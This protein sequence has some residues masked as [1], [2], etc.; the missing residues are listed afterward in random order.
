MRE[1]VLAVIN[2]AGKP[3]TAVRPSSELVVHILIIRSGPTSKLL[4]TL[5]APH[6]TSFCCAGFGKR[7]ANTFGSNSD[8]RVC[9][10]GE[11]WYSVLEN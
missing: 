11:L 5:T 4:V 10:T 6:G 8:A 3:F 9:A 1:D 2:G 7:P